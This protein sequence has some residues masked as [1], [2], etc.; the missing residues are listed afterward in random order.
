MLNIKKILVICCNLLYL[1]FSQHITLAQERTV[2]EFCSEVPAISDFIVQ[3]EPHSSSR[4]QFTAAGWRIPS[5]QYVKIEI[6]YSP[7]EM[8][9]SEVRLGFAWSG[10]VVSG[11]FQGFAN[12]HNLHLV[13]E[14]MILPKE[15]QKRI[16]ADMHG[17]GYEFRIVTHYHQRSE[18]TYLLLQSLII[19]WEPLGGDS[20]DK[21]PEE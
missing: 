18:Q 20:K 21:T 10:G 7:F 17:R 2:I 8:A 15:T 19:F 1:V 11:L 3:I 16:Y 13:F 4:V 12:K 9:I 5:G 6:P 14:E